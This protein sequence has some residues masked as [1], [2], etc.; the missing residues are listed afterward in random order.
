MTTPQ[1]RVPRTADSV[2]RRVPRISSR[3][4]RRP[5]LG[6]LTGMT[7]TPDAFDI[8]DDGASPVLTEDDVVQVPA[9]GAELAES[10]DHPHVG[11]FI[12]D[13]PAWDEDDPLP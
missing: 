13:V 3:C 8:V 6:Y 2:A 11:A 5:V 4:L 1:C 7:D 9:G 12:T 10:I